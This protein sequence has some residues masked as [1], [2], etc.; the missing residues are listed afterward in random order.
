MLL[1]TGDT[2]S[3]KTPA[4]L[5][6]VKQSET[7]YCFYQCRKCGTRSGWSMSEPEAAMHFCG[8]VVIQEAPAVTYQEIP[9]KNLHA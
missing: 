7:G 5:R 1:E 4:M 6:V 9:V 3:C 2:A 8:R